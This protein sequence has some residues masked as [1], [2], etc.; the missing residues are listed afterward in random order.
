MKQQAEEQLGIQ[1]KR[2]SYLETQKKRKKRK[3]RKTSKP[4]REKTGITGQM[5]TFY[6]NGEIDKAIQKAEDAGASNSL[7][8]LKKFRGVYKKGM[9]LSK[10]IGK[11]A[12]SLE[13]L[14]RAAKLDKEISRGSG[15]YYSLIRKQLAKIFF[16]KG[17]DA[18]MGRRYPEAYHAFTRAKKYGNDRSQQR[19]HDLEKTAKKLYEEAYVI[20]STNADQAIKKLNTVLK[21]IPPNHIYYSKAKRLRTNIQGPLGSESPDDSGF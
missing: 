1:K 21:I 10:N 9:E 12:K 8:K 20:K 3:R 11:A 19:L 15:K 4:K 13:F 7:V 17:V 2:I 5:L 16:L 18:M 14:T 6:R